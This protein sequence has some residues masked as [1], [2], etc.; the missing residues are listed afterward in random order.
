MEHHQKN[1]RPYRLM[2]THTGTGCNQPQIGY[3]GIC[4]NL[5]SVIL[6]NRQHGGHQESKAAD[7]RYHRTGQIALHGRRQTDQ[8]IYACLNHRCG[9]Q[10]RAGRRRRHHR[11]EKPARKRKLRTLGQS[12][13][14]QENNRYQCQSRL[15]VRADGES[16]KILNINNLKGNCRIGNSHRKAEA[17]QQVHPQSLKG[18][19]HCFIRLV[20]SDQEE[21]ADACNLPEEIDPCKIIGKYEPKHSP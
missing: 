12:C 8:Q 11:P 18:I 10:K 7:S 4:Q 15:R 14:R 19:L 20:I 2:H 17:A 6:G 9:M 1:G 3:C 5:L 21:G 13:K 16:H